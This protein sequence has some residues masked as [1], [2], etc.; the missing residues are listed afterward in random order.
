MFVD[1]MLWAARENLFSA[2]S[3]HV[4]KSLALDEIL[5]GLLVGPLAGDHVRGIVG[6]IFP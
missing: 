2:P 6:N 5:K 1:F 4:A 3:R